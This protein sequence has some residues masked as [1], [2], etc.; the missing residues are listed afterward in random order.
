M[1]ARRSRAVVDAITGHRDDR[2][3]GAPRLHD[4]ELLLGG[5]PGEDP[6]V[7]HGR[8][9]A[10]AQLLPDD[11][12]VGGADDAK[13]RGDRACGRRVVAGDQDRGDAGLLAGG[14]GGGGCR[15]RRV[16][17]GDQAQQRQA[18]LELVGVGRQG[19]TVCRR[20]GQDTVPVR[21]Q[22]IGASDGGGDR[23][24]LIAQQG[25][26][27]QHLGGPLAH[28]P[29]PPAREPVCRG[30][31]LA[32]AIE[33]ELGDPWHGPL[34]GH[35]V[36]AELGPGHQQRCLGRV[37]EGPPLGVVLVGWTQGRVVAEHRG[38]QQL[39]QLGVIVLGGRSAMADD[40]ALRRVAGPG[41]GRLARRCPQPL[42][43]HAALGE[44]PRL[45]GRDHGDRTERL[46]RRQAADDRVAGGHPA[47]A[48]RE[49]ERDHRRQR[50][51]HGRDDQA[52]RGHH[53]ELKRLPAQ[54]PEREHHRA[55]HHR[56]AGQH[57]AKANQA[58]LQWG[59]H[60][61]GPEQRRDPAHGAVRAG[62]GD[63][64]STATTKHDRAGRHHFVWPLA[65]ADRSLV[66]RHRLAGERLWGA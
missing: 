28:D 5:C 19:R 10:I 18:R 32:P 6:A 14:D 12:L 37:A 47:G 39:G 26:V 43:D 21:G 34:E 36:Q 1:S 57:T 8:D 20:Q 11:D 64:R 22:P 38:A 13:P 23:L 62:G 7:R 40:V 55:Q 54:Q 15:P 16:E 56:D 48:E 35:A 65:R 45:V 66:D 31:A 60:G 17:D 27:Q 33:R 30:H 25:P 9:S 41:E 44:R 53:H 46:H 52:D 24:G 58:P 2:P 4:V 50:L 49:A 51:G 59:Q 3:V 63:D 42:R 29:E 61:G